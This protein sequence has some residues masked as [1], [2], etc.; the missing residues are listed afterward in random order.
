M[1]RMVVASSLEGL[2]VGFRDGQDI[3]EEEPVHIFS[4]RR[5]RKGA[6]VVVKS[7]GCLQAS[8]LIDFTSKEFVDVGSINVSHVI[9]SHFFDERVAFFSKLEDNSNHSKCVS[10]RL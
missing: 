5:G 1:A 10:V 7:R 6:L 3:L 9:Y 4:A 2:Q 8:F